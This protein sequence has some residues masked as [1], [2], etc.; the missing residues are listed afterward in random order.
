MII[1]ND[2]HQDISKF[3][4]AKRDMT[5]I[6]GANI[7]VGVSDAF[8][9][10]KKA[11]ENWH[12]GYVK[13]EAFSQYELAYEVSETDFIPTQQVSAKQIWDEM[14][15]AARN[16]AEPGIVFMSRYNKISNSY[17]FNPVIAT[18][19]LKIA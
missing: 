13:P 9:E 12:T 7:S 19:P 15:Y 10:A 8:M 3:I 18:N 16:S 11:N 6:T 4:N 2:W 17:Y 5:L 14:M 1:L